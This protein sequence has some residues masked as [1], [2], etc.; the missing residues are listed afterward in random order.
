MK[1]EVTEENIVITVSKKKFRLIK[2]IIFEIFIICSVYAPFSTNLWWCAAYER[3]PA[4]GTFFNTVYFFAAGA[5]FA[6]FSDKKWNIPFMIYMFL[7]AA[8]SFAGLL[9]P[10]SGFAATCDVLVLP[11]YWG[12]LFA[13]DN[14]AV[15][16]SVVLIFAAAMMY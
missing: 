6:L 14:N 12:I 1:K 15:Y 8:G 2:N 13:T 9:F 5:V 4:L 10:E 11:T 3:E 16:Y 7:T